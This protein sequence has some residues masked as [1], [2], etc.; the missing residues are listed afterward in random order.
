MV[1]LRR[2]GPVAAWLFFAQLAL[3]QGTAPD[4]QKSKEHLDR[5][6]LSYD[7]GDFTTA[8]QEATLAV[9]ANP[10]NAAAHNC[11]GLVLSRQGE[12][13]GAMAAYRTALEIDPVNPVY[14]GNIGGIQY[15]RGEYTEAI[16]S[17][18]RAISAD[19]KNYR[20]YEY[21][22][23]VWTAKKDQAAADAD[24][25][26]AQSLKA[27]TPAAGQAPPA[28]PSQATPPKP[29][30]TRA[31]AATTT[32]TPEPDKPRVDV[33]GQEQELAGLTSFH[34][35]IGGNEAGLQRIVV[36]YV[37]E[38]VPSLIHLPDPRKLT[39][40]T[41]VLHLG[42]IKD[43]ATWNKG[44]V[45]LY[46]RTETR[47]IFSKRYQGAVESV[48]KDFAKDFVKLYKTVNGLK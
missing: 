36:N 40:A 12:L 42:G 13:A 17:L 31:S 3:A 21:R 8:L 19:S 48:A 22:A 15:R 18:T 44:E 28:S 34:V 2:F 6:R 4:L 33:V 16:D 32:P 10:R 27:A 29:A 25:K 5:A 30:A 11:R 24:L 38:K 1:S 35:A 39:A 37:A 20:Y 46:T 7:Q 41:M 47:R 14:L 26:M 43:Q 23:R 9:Q 45:V